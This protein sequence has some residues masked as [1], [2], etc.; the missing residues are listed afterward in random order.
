[1]F[2]CNDAVSALLGL[3]PVKSSQ[4]LNAT[5]DSVLAVSQLSLELKIP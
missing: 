2:H 4:E 3:W 1:M 5:I